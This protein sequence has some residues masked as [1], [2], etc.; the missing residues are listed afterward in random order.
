MRPGDSEACP[1]GGRRLMPATGQGLGAGEQG[2]LDSPPLR[3]PPLPTPTPNL[4]PAGPLHRWGDTGRLGQGEVRPKTL[5]KVEGPESWVGP[6]TGGRVPSMSESSKS[7][8]KSFQASVCSRTATLVAVVGSLGWR[9]QVS[10]RYLE[11]G[12]QPQP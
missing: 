12:V 3:A 9:W 10:G 4:G 2:N 1:G 11:N 6:R 5:R 8:V 7:R